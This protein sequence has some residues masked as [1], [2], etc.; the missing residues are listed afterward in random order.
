MYSPKRRLRLFRHP[1]FSDV[2]QISASLTTSLSAY[3]SA[4]NG[5][6][7][8]V[9]SNEY[10]TLQTNVA[11]TS[12][13]ATTAAQLA[14]ASQAGFTMSKFITTNTADANCPAI[15][16]NSYVY[17]ACY[18]YATAGHT[19]MQLYRNTASNVYSNFTQ[20]GGDL[21]TTVAGYNYAVLKDTTSTPVA[22]A[23][24]AA[25]FP[26]TSS[27]Q[28]LYFKQQVTPPTTV[29]AR[30]LI[31]TGPITTSTNIATQFNQINF[32]FQ[33]LSTTSKQW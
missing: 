18:R 22:N 1:A 5:T 32:M 6:W 19:G 21:P 27:P 11:N 31:T 33:T 9:T 3:T 13:G 15:P 2:D 29:S 10:A 12:L 24:L 20:I 25:L 30:Y 28:S 26:N 23:G 8:S 16:A 7:V 17:A 4:A 14:L